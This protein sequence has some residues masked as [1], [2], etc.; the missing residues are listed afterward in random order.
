[1][2]P[3]HY[4]DNDHEHHQCSAL[5]RPAVLALLEAVRAE[6]RRLV[7]EECADLCHRYQVEGLYQR[8]ANPDYAAATCAAL[9]LALREPQP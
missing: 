7:I 9:I 4:G 2:L 3:C 6:E 8:G 5:D 1:M